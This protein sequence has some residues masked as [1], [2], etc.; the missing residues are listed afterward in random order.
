MG[1]G[2][3]APTEP[4]GT[5]ELGREGFQGVV[6]VELLE[7]TM[8]KQFQIWLCGVKAQPRKDG[9]ICLHRRTDQHRDI[10]GCP[11]PQSHRTQSLTVCLLCPL[12]C[13]PSTRVQNECLQA[14]ICAL[15]LWR[16]PGFP[17]VSCLTQMDRIP[18]DF[19]SQMLHGL[20]NQ[21][22]H[23]IS[24]CLALPNPISR[25]RDGIFTGALFRCLAIWEDDR[26]IP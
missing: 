16:T 4:R 21:K 9:T 25:D 8:L 12:S 20:W 5:G 22:K 18:T 13:W 7:F 10:G 23:Q 24:G 1:P 26:F 14:R 15:A 2:Q 17:A 19:H 11:S 3:L 6:R